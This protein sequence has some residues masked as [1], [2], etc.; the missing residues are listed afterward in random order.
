MEI[1]LPYEPDI[2]RKSFA[3]V[4]IPIMILGSLTAT[5]IGPWSKSLNLMNLPLSIL[6]YTNAGVWLLVLW[7]AC[8][9]L[10]FQVA[11]LFRRLLDPVYDGELATT[12]FVILY[13]TC[14]DFVPD[15]LSSCLRQQYDPERFRVVIC[16]DSRDPLY[17]G[18]VNK[19]E[20]S[21]TI[22]RRSDRKG[23]KAGNVNYAV[24]SSTD[25]TDEWIV[26]VD[27]DQMLPE[28][29][30]RELASIIRARG[31][32][33]VAFVQAAHRSD[34]I[35]RGV[36]TR[37]S[38]RFQ[39][40]LGTEI[41]V[42]YQRD[43]SMRERF[44]L[45]PFLGHGAAIRRSSLV[46]LGGLPEIVSEDYAFT[47]RVLV[48]GQ[49]GIYA[50]G[51]SSW[52]S[53][54]KDFGAFATRLKKFSGGSAEL[55]RRE[56]GRFLQSPNVHLSEK[57]D[58][59]MLLFWY[60]LAPLV[61]L[62]LYLSAFVC[63]RLWTVGN[64]IPFLHPI[65]PYFF[66]LMLLISVSVILSVTKD[67]ERLTRHWFWAYAIY[68]STL[69]LSALHFVAHLWIDPTFV[70]TPKGSAH[71]Q[72]LWL[73]GSF[74]AL[75]GTATLWLSAAWYSPFSPILASYGLSFLLFPSFSR[76]GDN[77]LMGRIGRTLI[78]TPGI[79]FL[80]GLYVM[81]TRGTF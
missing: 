39:R 9:H 76:L 28:T 68:C 34:H 54:P 81:W 59:A 48:G 62:N 47:A 37:S 15:A 7:W 5:V 69:P 26:L 72:P 66:I 27:A 20:G 79:C 41:D 32:P 23:F 4:L 13:L 6:C 14:D 73:P 80:Y 22:I 33:E 17:I 78:W 77:S 43:L 55:L 42:F 8:H 3:L 49:V 1:R 24:S 56:A 50:E 21:A 60:V 18:Q 53:F 31:T 30:L 16:D 67:L 51:V 25:I 29:Y 61:F 19:C 44:G 12:R 75:A 36:P 35:L 2:R 65:L 40:A 58:F 11:A 63:H 74:I 52:E 45:I 57:L 46:A 71:S 10:V 64:G 70:R 38:T